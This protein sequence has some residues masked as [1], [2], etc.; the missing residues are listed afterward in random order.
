MRARIRNIALFIMALAAALVRRRLR[1]APERILVVPAGKLGDIVCTTP[2]LH[3][4]RTHLPRAKIFVAEYGSAEALLDESG[5]VDA[6]VPTRTLREYRTALR[7]ENIDTVLLTGP[8]LYDLAAALIARV[9]RIIAPRVVGGYCPQ[10]TRPYR[11]L[12]RFV[13]TFPYAIDAYAPRE[14]LRSLEPL[15]VHA[16]DTAKRLGFSD[17]ARAARTVFWEKHGLTEGSYAILSPGAGNKIKEWPGERFARVAEHIARKGVPV[18]VIGTARDRKETR[19][20]LKALVDT[21][22]IIDATEQLSLD[23]LKAVIA[24]AQ[25]FVSVDTGPLYIAE[26][27]GVPTI[28]IV[29]PV[30][31]RVQPPMGR[32][33]LVVVPPRRT[34]AELFIMNAR[35]YNEAEALRQVD[36]ITVRAVTDAIDSLLGDR[37][38]PS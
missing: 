23:E 30:D 5:L 31:E 2:V 32:R 15:G 26:A 11:V 29:G 19:N 6:Y 4:I 36:S 14:R 25:F 3:A 27:F 12:L 1:A 21:T 17:A 13:D 18:V 16:D 20:T 10:Q 37:E 22:R 24:G 28:D 34:K 8:A 7:R 38:L 9:P 33:H 35:S